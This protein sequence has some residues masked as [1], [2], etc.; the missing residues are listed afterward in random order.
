M[1]VCVE[2]FVRMY[3]CVCRKRRIYHVSKALIERCVFRLFGK[4]SYDGELRML[5]RSGFHSVGAAI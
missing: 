4:T 2:K 5:A 3:I 1:F